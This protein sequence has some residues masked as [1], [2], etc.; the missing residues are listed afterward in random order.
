MV[1]PDYGLEEFGHIDLLSDYASGFAWWKSKDKPP[2]V[3]TRDG[4]TGQVTRAGEHRLF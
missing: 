3:V 4:S 1:T 2:P